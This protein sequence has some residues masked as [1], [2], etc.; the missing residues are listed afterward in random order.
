M[1]L[2]ELKKQCERSKNAAASLRSFGARV[3]ALKTMAAFLRRDTG[4]IL[5]ANAK[6]MENAAGLSDAM[7]D[8][9]L[10][11]GERIEAIARSV[12]FLATL[13]DPLGDAETKT[14]E[15]GLRIV[16]TR[17]PLGVI[18]M[19]YEA[20]PNVTADAAALAVKSGNAVLLRGGKEAINSN[21]AIAAAIRGALN[22]A[23]CDGESVFAVPDTDR[24]TVNTMMSM[25]G[26]IDLIIPRGGKGLIG[27]VTENSK[28]PVIETGAGNCHVYLHR[29]AD[30]RKA[31]DITVN[32][33][34]S[35]PSVCN[36]AETLLCD[37]CAAERLLVPVAQELSKRGVTLR[38][39]EEAAEFVPHSEPATEDDFAREYNDMIMAVGLVGGV[40]EAIAH[41]NRYGTKHSEAIVTENADAA[42]RFVD[43]VDAAAV[44]V[45]ASTRFTDGGVYG[46]GAEIGISTQK[47]HVRG[48]FADEALT[49]VKYRVYGNGQIR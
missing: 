17:V 26:Y 32:A 31:I 20:R 9:L 29:D 47:L 44:Y 46:L 48:P 28:V 45:N 8:R 49:T 24:E 22:A 42:E 40:D 15:N 10:L 13:S 36:A 4:A 16:K 2:T 33:K 27:F 5:A 25:R 37:R 43:G 1:E 35:R 14:L 30:L 3:S 6:D 11:T 23:G 41:V 38:C 21:L 34:T 18:A 39:T 7:K 19:I 12:E